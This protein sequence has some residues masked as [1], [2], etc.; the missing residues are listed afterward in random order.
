MESM[1]VHDGAQPAW[2]SLAL[3]RLLW[4]K[5]SGRPPVALPT[6]EEMTR[7]HLQAGIDGGDYRTVAA[8]TVLRLTF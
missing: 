5:T 8:M 7:V 3:C 4:S 2:L 1:F 6:P